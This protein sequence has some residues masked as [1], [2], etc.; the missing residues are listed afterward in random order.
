MSLFNSL[1]PSPQTHKSVESYHPNNPLALAF[2]KLIF[3]PGLLLFCSSVFSHLRHSAMQRK[4]CKFSAQFYWRKTQH[5]CKCGYLN[6]ASICSAQYASLGNMDV[7]ATGPSWLF[8]VMAVAASSLG[9]T[10]NP[11]WFTDDPWRLCVALTW[12]PALDI[13]RREPTCLKMWVFGVSKQR[14]KRQ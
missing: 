4:E 5:T 13:R 6:A 3:Y 7:S 14:R 8:R 2:P 11:P 1:L 10:G 9:A 12:E